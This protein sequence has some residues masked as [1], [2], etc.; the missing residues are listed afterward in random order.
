MLDKIPRS[1]DGENLARA[2]ANSAGPGYFV[3]TA[4]AWEAGDVTPNAPKRHADLLGSIG[5]ASS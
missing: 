3:F 1:L 2:L 4:A 5:R